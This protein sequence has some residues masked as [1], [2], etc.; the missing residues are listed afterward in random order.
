[1]T[2]RYVFGLT[3]LTTWYTFFNRCNLLYCPFKLERSILKVVGVAEPLDHRRSA[4]AD[5][6]GIKAV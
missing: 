1:M 5:L 4:M 6:Y 3:V 2:I